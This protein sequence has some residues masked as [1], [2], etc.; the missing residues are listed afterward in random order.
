MIHSASQKLL[1][2]VKQSATDTY[3]NASKRAIHK[4]TKVSKTLP[5]NSS[6]TVKK[7]KENREI[8]KGRYISP[9]K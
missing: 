5:Q 1:E 4:S 2:H 9:E 7:G 8:P 3:K 6:E